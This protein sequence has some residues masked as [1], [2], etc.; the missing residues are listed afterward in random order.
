MWMMSGEERKKMAKA[1]EQFSCE[2]HKVNARWTEE[3]RAHIQITHWTSLLHV[4]A[5]SHD[6]TPEVHKNASGNKLLNCTCTCS[7]AQASLH[8]SY[9]TLTPHSNARRAYMMSHNLYSGL[10]W[11]SGKN[12]DLVASP[13]HTHLPARNCLVKYVK[14]LRLIKYYVVL[15]LQQ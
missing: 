4:S 1:W 10:L 3:G 15:P 2:W 14:F 6:K 8:Y 7:R 13:P 5:L 9:T 11:Y 12:F